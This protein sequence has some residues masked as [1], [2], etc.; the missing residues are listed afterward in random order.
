MSIK[1]QPVPI[2]YT[3]PM[4]KLFA[5]ILLIGIAVAGGYYYME[6]EG[7]QNPLKRYEKIINLPTDEQAKAYQETAKAWVKDPASSIPYP[8]GWN[9]TTVTIQGEEIEVFTSD[10]SVPPNYY[11]SAEF[12]KKFI[13]SVTMARCLNLNK[14]KETDWCVIGDNPQVNAYFTL[15]K[16]FKENSILNPSEKAWDGSATAPIFEP[17]QFGSEAEPEGGTAE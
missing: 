16:W 11:V 2:C 9:K 17:V 4:K 10:K 13:P 1:Y 7:I 14:S 8:K 12:P 5:F 15:V 3:F 6:R